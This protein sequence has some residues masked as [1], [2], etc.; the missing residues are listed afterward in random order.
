MKLFRLSS[1]NFVIILQL[2]FFLFIG[3]ANSQSPSILWQHCYGGSLSDQG[4][5]LIFTTDGGY[6]MAGHTHSND[7]DV[8]NSHGNAD[9]WVVKTDQFGNIQWQKTIGGS[10]QEWYGSII[11]T[12]DGGFAVVGL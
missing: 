11:Q 9:L 6:A 5:S 8:T 7:G 4:F 1:F 2:F 12:L 10:D 3:N